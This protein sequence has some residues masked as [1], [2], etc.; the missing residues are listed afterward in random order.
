[1]PDLQSTLLNLDSKN[2]DDA[3]PLRRRLKEATSEAILQAA[4]GTFAESGLHSARM[5]DIARR[6]GVS[7]GTLYNYFGD[8]SALL[9]VLVASRR[10]AL[11]AALD[12]ASTEREE[13]FEQT[14]SRLLRV[15]LEHY[16]QHRRFFSILLEGELARDARAFPAAASVPRGTMRSLH[17]RF[18]AL[19]AQGVASG[20][21][22]PDLAELY[23]ALLMGMV[24]GI[25]IH[26]LFQPQPTRLAE[27]V[28]DLVELFLQGAMVGRGATRQGRSGRRG[29]SRG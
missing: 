9:E 17:Q 8:R 25:V 16:D 15:L 4:E 20:V 2:E 21:L 23:P 14:L 18:A 3:Q 29:G 10:A 5:E 13:R 27:H 26:S 7:V 6:A 24:R 22:R 19:S 28:D 12:Q 1:L 11:V